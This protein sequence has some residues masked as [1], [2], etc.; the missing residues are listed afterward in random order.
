MKNNSFKIAFIILLVIASSSCNKELKL[1]DDYKDQ[2]II[3][4]LINPAD[5]ISYIRIQKAYLSDGDIFEDEQ[6][7]DSNIYTHKLDV[8]IKSGNKVIQFDTMTIR[9]KKEGTFFYPDYPI[10]YAVTKDLLDVDQ[11]LEL[12]VKNPKSGNVA[13]STAHLMDASRLNIIRPTFYISLLENTEIDFKTLPNIWFYQLVIRFHYMEMLPN[14]SSSQ[15]YKY[16]DLVSEIKKSYSGDGGEIMNFRLRPDTFLG[17]LSINISSSNELERYLGRIE[18]IINT[19]EQAFFTYQQ[20]VQPENSV[21][22]HPKFYTNI[23]NGF[24]IFAGRSSCSRI[25][26][27]EVPSKPLIMDLEGLNFIG[28]IYGD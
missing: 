7:I 19:T 13:T 6:I 16:V 26:R 11:A 15:V 18:L 5:S 28:S 10:Y 4:G 17:N 3:Y 27:V 23:E 21:L 22:E 9:N 20:S 12:E 2:P 8:S 25:V 14:D 1:L 24:G